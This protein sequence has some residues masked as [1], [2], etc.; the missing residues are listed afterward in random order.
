VVSFSGNGELL[1]AGWSEKQD[2]G[3]MVQIWRV[4]SGRTLTPLFTIETNASGVGSLALSPN[5]KLL[6]V[7]SRGNNV[8]LFELFPE[9]QST[10][11]PTPLPQQQSP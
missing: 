1:A 8:Q 6:A 10:P 9:A 3:G 7:A 4:N 2:S 5:G 11:A